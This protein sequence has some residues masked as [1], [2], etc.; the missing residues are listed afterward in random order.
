MFDR[1]YLC[2]SWC[3]RLP[4]ENGD[5]SKLDR[6]A[7]HTP[8]GLRQLRRRPRSRRPARRVAHGCERTYRS[9]TTSNCVPGEIDTARC[10]LASPAG[11]NSPSPALNEMTS[12]LKLML[13]APFST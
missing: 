5:R 8:G 13:N 9:S 7:D 4:E 11:M 6:T 12:P 10:L 1:D 3:P 2:R